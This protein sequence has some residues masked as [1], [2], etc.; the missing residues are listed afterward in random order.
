MMRRYRPGTWGARLC[1]EKED[2][3]MLEAIRSGVGSWFVKLF[4]GLLI[5]SFA[6]WGIGD[7]FRTSIDD[8][9]AK[10]D[11][12]KIPGSVFAAEFNRQLRVM[13]SQYGADLDTE[14]AL[15]LGLADTVLNRMIARLAFD[16]DAQRKGLRISDQRVK[17]DI[18]SNDSFK[19]E[20]GDFD[21]FRFGQLIQAIGM[22]E[23]QFIEN[24][25]ADIAREQLMNGLTAGAQAPSELA[26]L[27]YRYLFET[28]AADYFTI[29]T[30]SIS[31]VPRPDDEALARFH[32]ENAQDFMAPE[33]R[34]LTYVMI[35]A[36]DLASE[37]ELSDEDLRAEFEA[38]KYE[39]GNEERRVVDHIVFTSSEQAKAARARIA[40][41]EDFATVA[42]AISGGNEVSLGEVTRSLLASIVGEEAAATVFSLPEGT[43]S[44]PVETSF[45]WHLFR[46]A[47]VKPGTIPPFEA[48][49][50]QVRE[51][52]A[53]E[54]A[55]DALYKIANQLDD[56]LASGAT[57]EEAAQSAGLPVRNVAA[58]DRS[59]RDPSGAEVPGLPKTPEFLEAAFKN[60]IGD[61]LYLEETADGS[62]FLVRVD[63]ITPAK[64]RPLDEIRD[65]VKARWI[66]DQRDKLARA[67]AEEAVRGLE[68]GGDLAAL[69]ERLGSRPGHVEALRRDGTGAPPALSRT[70]IGKLFGIKPNQATFGP[71]ARQDGY[72]V[73]RLTR[74]TPGDPTMDPNGLAALRASLRQGIGDDILEQYQAWL[75]DE[76]G[77]KVNRGLMSAM[78]ENTAGG[79]LPTTPGRNF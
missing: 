43:V 16:L 57:L 67:R 47:A 73:A 63:D 12:A 33:Y 26:R 41:G 2:A 5:A 14:A 15:R 78:F 55:T 8:S 79:M 9:V 6:I 23:A 49:R 18:Q 50:D 62:Y 51:K 31:D 7:T 59:G 45:G 65:K 48:V 27:L 32:K 24:T 37:V 52:L 76:F 70:V 40:Q 58:V 74:V 44:D 68:Q 36:A 35:D 60:E 54:H 30:K 75:F 22:T 21:R 1:S 3:D 69:A 71:T 77:V 61:D 29:S 10:V 46:I 13:Q 72:I 28:R 34:K 20:F 56:L 19:N 66:A 53:R 38:R 11:D 25:R 39:F 42:T 17:D 64:L 4:L